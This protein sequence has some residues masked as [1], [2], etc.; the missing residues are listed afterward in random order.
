MPRLSLALLLMFG[1]SA[2]AEIVQIRDLEPAVLAEL[3]RDFDFWG[4]DRAQNAAVFDL[5]T[6]AQL[7]LRARGLAIVPD[8]ARQAELEAWR[9]IDRAAWRAGSPGTIPGFSCYRTVTQTHADLQALA[10]R[11]PTRAEWRAIGDTWQAG[12]GSAPGDS[13]FALV[14]ANHNSNHARA[15]LVIMA[16]QHARELAT[17]EIATRFAE[18]IL[19]NPDDDPDLAWLVDHRE[20]HIIAQQNPDGRRQVEAGSLFWRKNHNETV[21][22]GGNEGVDLNRNSTVLWGA[23][24]SSSPCS[25]TYRGGAAGSEPETQA[26]EA[27]LA[28]V[29]QRQRPGGGLNDPAP[30]DA[31]GLFLS[32]HSFG[33][34]VLFPWEGLAVGNQNNAP[35]HDGLATLGRRFGFE[36]GYEVGRWELLGPAGGTMV[37]YAYGEFGVAAYTFEVGTSFGQSCTSFESTVWPDN[38]EALKLAAK[39][40]RRPYQEP[41]GPAISQLSAVLEQG[42]V[43]L[44]GQADDSRYF[45]GNVSEPPAQDPISEVVTIR[46]AL[47]APA[48]S[49]ATVIDVPLGIPAVVAEFDVLLPPATPL[50]A[51]GRLF[52]TAV[53]SS[54]Q[55]GLPRVV[56]VPDLLFNDG[57]EA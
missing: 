29:F 20:I 2:A 57:F 4:L 8:R 7:R 36:T 1:G 26:V 40:A 19:D 28:T 46:V 53:D 21:C 23:F 56:T 32:L 14:I 22:T 43:R 25:D 39:A 34:L 38:R 49:A 45:R 13:L 24:S 37:D 17:A 47:G 35:N 12:A 9:R 30:A 6:E 11:H 41:A 18:L 51:N 31:E 16:A 10:L 54:G 3:R 5:S 15:P 44:I 48:E 33:E 27:Y 52:V 55:A 42:R 50:P